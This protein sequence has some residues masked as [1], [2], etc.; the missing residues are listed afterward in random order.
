LRLGIERERTN[1]GEPRK[2]AAKQP[3]KHQRE[4]LT[5]H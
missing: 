3:L 5:E 4:A 2:H 1:T